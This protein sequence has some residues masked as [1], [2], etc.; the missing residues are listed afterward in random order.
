MSTQEYQDIIIEVKG[1]S[2]GVIQLNRPKA[3]NA[4]RDQLM[5][6]LVDALQTF[7]QEPTIGSDCDYR[8]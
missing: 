7:D 8:Q 2:V 3:L 6:E 1:G 4:L 5:S